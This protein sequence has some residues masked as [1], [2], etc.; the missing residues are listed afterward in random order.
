[1]SGGFLWEYGSH[2]NRRPSVPVV[3][4]QRQNGGGLGARGNL[5][6]GARPGFG[7]TPQEGQEGQEGGTGGRGLA[8]NT[9]SEYYMSRLYLNF[10]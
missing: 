5:G 7:G 9:G 10:C 1:M 3:S 4:M 8:L 6:G 2:Q